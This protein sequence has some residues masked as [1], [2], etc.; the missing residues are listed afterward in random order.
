MR[1]KKILKSA[2]HSNLVQLRK[3]S[4]IFNIFNGYVHY[5]SVV[6]NKDDLIFYFDNLRRIIEI[7]LNS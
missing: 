1:N 3:N 4:R 2:E 7:C 6:P 5:D